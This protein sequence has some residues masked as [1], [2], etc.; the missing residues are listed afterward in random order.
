M[1]L[2]ICGNRQK[3]GKNCISNIFYCN[4]ATIYHL[5]S[6]FRDSP[7][8]IHV[9][10]NKRNVTLILLVAGSS[11]NWMW[12]LVY[13]CYRD[14]NLCKKFISALDQ[15]SDFFL[16]QE[17]SHLNWIV[18][19]SGESSALFSRRLSRQVDTL[20]QSREENTITDLVI[21]R[22]KTASSGFSNGTLQKEQIKCKLSQCFQTHLEL[23]Y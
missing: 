20:F 1:A 7:H 19:F 14:I 11:F 3:H 6:L 21:A 2:I 10:D 16:K 9:F 17:S 13:F 4:I 12:G 23:T 15:R 8:N 18:S 22:S 5:I